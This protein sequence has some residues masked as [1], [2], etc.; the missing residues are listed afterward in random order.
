MTI[1]NSK[2]IKTL[3]ALRAIA[4]ICVFLSHTGFSC[5]GS[6]GYFGVS[7]FFV[8]TGFVSI[9]SQ[10]GKD[11]VPSLKN[12]W[13]YMVSKI[14]KLYPLHI[15]TMIC[16]SVF[17]IFGSEKEPLIKTI[18]KFILNIFLVQEWFPL[19]QRD[20]N[21]VS[22]FLCVLLIAYL[23]F[24]WILKKIKKDHTVRK[25]KLHIVIFLCAE[26]LVAL[27]G[28][29]LSVIDLSNSVVIDG[30]LV[31]WFVS[32]FP[33]FRLFE[34]AIGYNLGYIYLQDRNRNIANA[35][36]KEIAAIIF[37]LICI[38][39]STSSLSNTI[40]DSGIL[41]ENAW[42]NIVIIYTI[43]SMLLIYLFA[44]GK[45]RLSNLLVNKFTMYIASISAYG[46]L[47]HYVIFRY[48]TYLFYHVVPSG[49]SYKYCAYFKLT[50]GF[51]LT[52]ICCEV[53][54]R[55]QKHIK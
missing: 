25:A 35:T 4:F 11:I 54:K 30:C 50:V 41:N 16:M 55:I 8:L 20:L 49:I 18:V 48:I 31:E 32:R 15:V 45:G 10:Y 53:W 13:N 14:K 34:V 23:I 21:E 29:Q 33:L 38:I 27:L 24:P 44:Y 7:I 36:L 9:V 3:E 39:I 17:C 6:I 46:F 42:W 26:L 19:K 28:K 47:I 52:I 5:F 22:W 12:N 51:I 37:A 43:P 40:V 1:T 2:R